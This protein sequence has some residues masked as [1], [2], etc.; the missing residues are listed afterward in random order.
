MAVCELLPRSNVVLRGV[1]IDYLAV[2]E[3]LVV[4]HVITVVLKASILIV[5]HRKGRIDL[6]FKL[7]S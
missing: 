5:G 3:V 1:Q 7:F 2:V 4:A 6:A